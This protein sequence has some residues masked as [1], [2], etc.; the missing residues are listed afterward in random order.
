M[1]L[2]KRKT[3]RLV[4]GSIFP[5]GYL[6]T[7][8][9]VLPL[10]LATFFLTLLLALEYERYRS[11]ALWNWLLKHTG[12]IFKT[13]PGRLT[14]D[15]CFMLATFIS[16]LFFPRKVAIANLYFL[17]FGDAAS[18]LAGSKWGKLNIF[19]GK[20]LEGMLAG[21]LFNSLVGFLLLRLLDINFE[22]L[23]TGVLVGGILEVL[24]LNIDDNLTIGIVPGLLMAL[25]DV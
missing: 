6:L 24:P 15:T 19:P 4:M 14:G 9:S 11:P 16:L 2:W 25:L 12:G 7:G 1:V 10:G 23:F 21:I 5:T 18:A 8:K 20:T 22:I 17:V 3:Y 13:R